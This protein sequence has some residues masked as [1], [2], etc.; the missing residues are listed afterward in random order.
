MRVLIRS[1]PRDAIEATCEVRAGLPDGAY[2][3]VDDSGHAYPAQSSGG[4]LSFVVPLLRAGEVRALRLVEGEPAAQLELSDTGSEVRV[5]RGGFH[6]ASYRYRGA[7]VPHVYPLNAAGAAS[8]TEDA[9]RDHPHHRSLWTAHGDVNGVDFWAGG[10]EIR[11]LRFKRLVA[12]PV[13]AE[14]VAENSWESGGS[15]LILEERRVRIWSVPSGEW[16]VDYEVALEPEG[17]VVLGD[18]KEAGILSLRVASSMTV[19]SGGRLTNSW[20]GVNEGE[21]WGRRAEWCDYSGPLA[22]SVWGVAA[23]DHPSNP[24]HPTY[25]HARDY[26]LMAANVFGLSHFVGRREGDMRLTAPVRFRYRLLIHRGWAH[27]AHVGLRYL[28][29]VYPP[30]AELAEKV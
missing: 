24:R 5:S 14:I 16:L 9:P 17:E 11:H 8:V 23:F 19:L 28:N 25:W 22:G 2:L 26:G 13:Y 1:G 30:R 27:E 7:R 6:V 4:V 21:V 15:R 3:L 20:G 10:G 18:T 12:G 29:W